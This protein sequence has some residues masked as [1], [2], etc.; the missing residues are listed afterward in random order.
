[1]VVGM[2]HL[3]FLLVAVIL[4]A[5]YAQDT[6]VDVRYQIYVVSEVTTDGG[7]AEE[8]F[9]EATMAR[10]GQV[11]EYR[12]FAVNVG[13]TTLPAGTVLIIGP[14]PEGTTFVEGSATPSSDRVLTEYS[15][16]EGVTYSEP[17]VLVT[18]NDVTALVEAE[19]YTAVRWT[20][21]MPLEPGAE[22]ALRYRVVI[23]DR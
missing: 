22:E 9:S 1:M 13:E 12:L 15:G 18:R 5:A 11:V 17:P 23:M 14:V 19:D 16:D 10:P 20:L 6:P 21:L 7:V 3:S 4:A 8:R 2:R